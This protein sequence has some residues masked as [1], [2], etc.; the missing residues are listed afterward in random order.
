[1]KLLHW[2]SIFTSWPNVIL[3]FR[4][5]ITQND[6]LSWYLQYIYMFGLSNVSIIFFCD[7]CQN[8]ILNEDVILH[9]SISFESLR[10]MVIRTCTLTFF[11]TCTK[12]FFSFVFSSLHTRM[13]HTG[14]KNSMQR[15]QWMVIKSNK[16]F[17]SKMITR[18]MPY[19]L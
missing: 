5:Y 6:F 14:R 15:Q 16:Q 18:K 19:I 1:M 11:H 9:L 13:T 3:W 17:P 8:H 2:E 7:F 12:L 4:N 10:T